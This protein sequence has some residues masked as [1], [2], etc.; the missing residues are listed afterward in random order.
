M[1]TIEEAADLSGIEQKTLAD[2]VYKGY[3]TPAENRGT[4]RGNGFRFTMQQVAALWVFA[5][6]HAEFKPVALRRL[7]HAYSAVPPEWYEEEFAAGRVLHVGAGD[8]RPVLVE[9]PALGEPLS[10]LPTPDV[11]KFWAT[12]QAKF[13]EKATAKNSSRAAVKG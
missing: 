5:A 9:T 2:Y 13:F 12:M 4:G 10:H 7:L 6:R 3:V 11:S 1:F 8:D